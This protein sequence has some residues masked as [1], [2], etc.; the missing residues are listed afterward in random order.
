MCTPTRACIWMYM[1]T[2]TQTHIYTYIYIWSCTNTRIHAHTYR[3]ACMCTPTHRQKISTTTPQRVKQYHRRTYASI[4]I[5]MHIHIYICTYTYPHPAVSVSQMCLP[6]FA[7]NTLTLFGY[8][9]CPSSWNKP[10]SSG[11]HAHIFHEL[12]P[13]F[14]EAS[15][16]NRYHVQEHWRAWSFC[17]S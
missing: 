13:R 12:S 2:Y 8:E 6:T 17:T 5:C 14:C 3:Y 7:E 11:S 10:I 4:Y 15:W 16:S 1:H 9:P